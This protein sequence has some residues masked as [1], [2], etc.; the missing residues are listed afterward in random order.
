MAVHVTVDSDAVMKS[1]GMRFRHAQGPVSEWSNT[2]QDVLD[3]DPFIL[4]CE[5]WPAI[6]VFWN[7]EPLPGELFESVSSLKQLPYRIPLCFHI[8]DRY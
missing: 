4:G 8:D 1:N 5:L 7:F 3:D 2:M 6:I